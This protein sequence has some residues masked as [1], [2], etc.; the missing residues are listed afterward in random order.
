MD[1]QEPT[2]QPE[3]VVQHCLLV[4]EGKA[5]ESWRIQGVVENG[6]FVLRGVGYRHWIAPD[7]EFPT[8]AKPPWAVY[9]RVTGWNTGPTRVFFRVHYRNQAGHWEHLDQ[10]EMDRA[11]AFPDTGENTRD[12]ILNLPYLRLGGVGLHAISVHFWYDGVRLDADDWIQEDGTDEVPEWETVPDAIFSTP[13]W[14]FGGADY[15]L[16]ERSP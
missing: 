12:V 4:R 1:E 15:F 9:L 3:V 13:D 10:R 2:K 8:V 16:I 7:I 11:L 14:V 5:D 6:P